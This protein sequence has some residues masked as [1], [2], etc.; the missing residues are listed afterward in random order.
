MR[1]VTA[2]S[3][4]AA[5]SRPYSDDTVNEFLQDATIGAA[6]MP[7]GRRSYEILSDAWSDADD[8]EPA[9]A[10]MNR[11]PKDVVS[12][13]LNDLSVAELPRDHRRHGFRHHG[14]QGPY[15]R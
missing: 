9:V 7:L 13:S 11:M 8:F 14:H 1:I 15:R 5:G 12:S 3:D 4:T 6:G 2:D 10:A